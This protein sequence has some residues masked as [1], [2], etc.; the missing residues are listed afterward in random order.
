M[1]SRVDGRSLEVEMT[2]LAV[3]STAALIVASA[4]AA[5]CSYGSNR[6]G[7][8]APSRAVVLSLANPFGDSLELDGFAREVK[9][10]SGGELRI[11]VRSRWRFGQVASEN[12]EIGDVRA[13]KADLGVA[14]SRAWD[15]V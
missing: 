8:K 12:G 14:G 10:L 9:R 4:L 13:G 2:R 5:G 15:S 1:R 3:T 7:G 11:D 6:A